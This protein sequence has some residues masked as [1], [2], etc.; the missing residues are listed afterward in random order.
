MYRLR[1]VGKKERRFLGVCGGIS[2][3]INPDIDPVGI[4]ILWVILTIFAA[5]PM[6]FLYLILAI[7]LKEE[8]YEIKEEVHEA[9]PEE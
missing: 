3:Y 8:D 6:I 7:V 2:K 4:R 1:K 9:E 5:P